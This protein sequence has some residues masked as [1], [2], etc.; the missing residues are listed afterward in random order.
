M[1]DI[2]DMI[3]AER[4]DLALLLAGLPAERWDEPTLCDGWRVTEVVAH[5]TMPFR[6][7]GRRYLLE[8]AKSRGNFNAMSDRVARRDAGLLTVPELT[9]A[10]ADNVNHP[11]K[12]PGGGYVGALTHD[13]VHGM[14]IS[15]A[16]G[17]ER[18]VPADRLGMILPSLTTPKIG[19]YFGVD[20]AGIQLRAS[21]IGWT[22]GTGSPVT[23]AAQHL[24]LLLCGRKLPADSLEGEQSGRFTVG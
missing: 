10:V 3:A 16:L 23:G 18:T 8:L 15:V 21:D 22:F 6:Y 14:D 7:P 13:I 20:L 24:A 19:K 1:D 5:I 12:P 17:I 4:R 2:R 9:A 11:W